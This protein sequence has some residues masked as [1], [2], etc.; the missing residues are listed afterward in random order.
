MGAPTLDLPWSI[1]PITWKHQMCHLLVT[2]HSLGLAPTHSTDT[3]RGPHLPHVTVILH[4]R[5]P[6][7]RPPA[8]MVE[9][10]RE[11]RRPATKHLQEWTYVNSVL[12]RRADS[13]TRP[14]VAKHTRECSANCSARQRFSNRYK[15]ELWAIHPVSAHTSGQRGLCTRTK[16]TRVP[17]R[18]QRVQSRF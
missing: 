7:L 1:R 8:E 13:E 14:I 4:D 15:R 5:L 6:L 2:S 3:E 11:W 12:V 16:E 17:T 10:T 9:V 18:P